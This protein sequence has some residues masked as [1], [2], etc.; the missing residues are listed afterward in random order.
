MAIKEIRHAA[1]IAIGSGTILISILGSAAGAQFSTNTIGCAG[2]ATISGK[3]GSTAVAVSPSSKSSVVVTI[4]R[5]GTVSWKGGTAVPVHAH[6]GK[7][8]VNLGPFPLTVGKWSGNNDKDLREKSGITQL[9]DAFKFVLPGTYQV[10]G[11]HKGK[12][13]SCVGKAS[14]VIEGDALSSPTGIAV[15]AGTVLTGAGLFSAAKARP[16]KLG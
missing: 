4:P 3:T 7:V 8:Q 2:S 1:T 12:E 5:E 16:P 13:G 14:L 9:P 10:T 11:S 15:A 6:N